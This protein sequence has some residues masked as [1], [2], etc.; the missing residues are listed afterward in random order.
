MLLIQ[1][2]LGKSLRSLAEELD[3]EDIESTDNN[4]KHAVASQKFKKYSSTILFNAEKYWSVI[5]RCLDPNIHIDEN[6][7]EIGKEALREVIYDSIIRPLEDELT[8]SNICSRDFVLDLDTE[9]PKLD[10]ANLGQPIQLQPRPSNITK[11]PSKVHKPHPGAHHKQ[12]EPK[13]KPNR[14]VIIQDTRFHQVGGNTNFRLKM[15]C[16]QIRPVT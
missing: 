7:E 1:I 2:Y 3:I 13:E 10:L 14:N 6:G 4:T 16:G 11:Y 9:A 12:L 15:S 5:D 8:Q